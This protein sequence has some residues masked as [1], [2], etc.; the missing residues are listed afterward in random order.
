MLTYIARR[1]LFLPVVLIGVTLL[2]FLA[3]SFLTPAQ[4]VS[5]YIKSP[6]ELKNQSIQELVA[7]YGLDQPVWKRYF[8]W[9]RNVLKGDL[10]YSV[11]ANMY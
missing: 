5:A 11:S 7:K 1:L 2:I 4:L 10:G 6:E 9:M 8:S 3:M